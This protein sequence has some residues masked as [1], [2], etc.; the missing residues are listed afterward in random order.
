MTALPRTPA[1]RP[2]R[3]AVGVVGAGRAGSVLGAALARA[4]HRVAAASAVSGASRA[5]VEHWLPGAPV[6]PVD[7]VVAAAELVLVAVPDD[8]LEP[9]VAGLAHAGTWRSGQLVAHVSGA[10]GLAVL[11]PAAAAGAL[12]LAL[13][14]IMTFTGRDEDATRLAG[15]HWGV[16]APEALRPIAEALV[17]EMGGEPLWIADRN[18]PLYHAALAMAANHLVTLVSDARDAL[19]AAGVP[20]PSLALAPLAGAALDN[21]LRSGDA[22]L[23]GPVVRG[24]AGTV[25]AH[26]EALRRTVPETVPAYLAMARRSADRAIAVGRLTPSDAEALLGVLTADADG[27]PA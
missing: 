27:S 9:L 18:R 6:L 13:H 5:R 2:G 8:A 14:P 12:P 1:D 7:R 25:A 3:L 26:L 17:V 22:A 20:D 23:T 21:A 11:G 24:D 15:A 10:H 4:G 16:T 19:R